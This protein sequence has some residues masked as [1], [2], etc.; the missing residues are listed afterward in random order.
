M[1]SL[2]LPARRPR[3]ANRTGNQR[4]GAA[5]VEFAVIAPIMLVLTLGMMEVGRMVMVKQIMVNATREG[6][7]LAILPEVDAAEVQSEV[8]EQ[9]SGA[10]ISGATITI[11]PSSLSSAPAGTPVTV[12]ASIDATSISW[13]PKPLISLQKTIAASTTMRREAQ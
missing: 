6:A 9:L 2:T 13:V 5:T 12:S 8:E 1:K 4:R 3:S 10:G 7:R 11:T